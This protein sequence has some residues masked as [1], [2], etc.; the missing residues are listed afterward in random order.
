[1]CIRVHRI[2]LLYVILIGVALTG[3]S[4]HALSLVC[5]E[6][7]SV[8]EIL[9]ESY[10]E[11]EIESDDVLGTHYSFKMSMEIEEVKL[12]D[13]FL[14]RRNGKT[15]DF[16]VHLNYLKFKEFVDDE[17][18]Y[19]EGSFSLSKDTLDGTELYAIYNRRYQNCVPEIR[20]YTIE[21][22]H[23]KFKNENASKAGSD[24]FSTRPFERR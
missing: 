3:S 2:N 7:K 10:I 21:I 12:D 16:F 23:N 18:S 5:G 24:A 6:P 19:V 14:L 20:K 9:P 8:Q 17:H 1:M 13:I 4:A 15:I 22:P 11:W